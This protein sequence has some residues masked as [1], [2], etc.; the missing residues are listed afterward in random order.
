MDQAQL[1]MSN[2][3]NNL[4][5]SNNHSLLVRKKKSINTPGHYLRK[6]GKWAAWSQQKSTLI[7]VF[8]TYSLKK[9]L[10]SFAMFLSFCF[11]LQK[12]CKGAINLLY[13]KYNL[14]NLHKQPPLNNGQFFQQL[15]KGSRMV[16]RFNLCGVLMIYQGNCILHV[17]YLYCCGKHNLSTILIAKCWEPWLF[18]HISILIQN[19]LQGFVYFISIFIYD[20]NTTMGYSKH[21]LFVSFYF[22]ASKKQRRK[23]ITQTKLEEKKLHGINKIDSM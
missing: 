16:M 17:C 1:P 7:A 22:I 13:V 11:F 23:K 15:M 6:Y 12:D 19:V 18:C 8:R 9:L 2:I 10:I 3:G 14:L 5:P 20:W 21:E 4:L